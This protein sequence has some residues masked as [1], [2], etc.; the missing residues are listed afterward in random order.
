MPHQ[1]DFYQAY[2]RSLTE[3]DSYIYHIYWIK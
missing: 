1:V 2:K 3:E